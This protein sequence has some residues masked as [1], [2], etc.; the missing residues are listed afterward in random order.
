MVCGLGEVPRALFSFWQMLVIVDQ[1][2]W[3]HLLLDGHECANIFAD[4]LEDFDLSLSLMREFVL[5]KR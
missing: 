1:P 4:V 3:S 5:D 2:V